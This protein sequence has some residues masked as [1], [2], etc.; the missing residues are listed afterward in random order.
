[1][2]YADLLKLCGWE[3]D[4][5]AREKP[6]LDE[7][8]R[9]LDLGPGEMK[10]AEGRVAE[11]YDIDLMGVRKALGV[12]IGG[13]VDVVL[14]KKE[15][16][17]V[18]YYSFPPLGGLGGRISAIGKGDI[19]CVCPEFILDIVLGAIFDRID[20]IME[21]GEEK[22]LPPGRALC[23]MNKIRIGA[24]A[25]GIIPVPDLLLA[26]SFYCDQGGQTDEWLHEVYGVPW[27]VMDNVMDSAWDEFPNITPERISYMAAE[28]EDGWTEA[29]K[30]LGQKPDEKHWGEYSKL[31]GEF[32][33]GIAK[34]N[35]AMKTDPPPISQ[36]NLQL[37]R[38]LRNATSYDRFPDALKA[39]DLLI[40]ELEERVQEGAG[41]LPKGSPRVCSFLIPQRDQSVAH[42]IEKAG[43][44][45]PVTFL[46]YDAYTAMLDTTYTTISEKS[47]Q[48]ELSR[49]LYHSTSAILYWTKKAVEDFDLDGVLWSQPIHCRPMASSGFVLKKAIES[50]MH[51]PVLILEVDWYDNR[52]F[53]GETM[54]TKIETFGH[55]LAARKAKEQTTQEG[56]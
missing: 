9:I 53:S 38:F 23:A 26:S 51:I 56:N 17:K 11:G 54:R 28:I 46:S 37:V 41:P 3:E 35:R 42:L 29:A 5:M 30:I 32:V 21:T 22:A 13:L 33:A 10:I 47:A 48:T 36:S 1:V 16:K 50:E 12:W 27:V 15:G 18:V 43:I 4:Q 31:Y 49:G 24:I 25:K 2:Y 39:I 6:R 52:V 7:A 20:P 34:T 14:S 19:L 55:L 8:F 40:P 45:I 44:A